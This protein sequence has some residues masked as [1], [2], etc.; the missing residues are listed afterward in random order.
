MAEEPWTMLEY[1]P[2]C[3]SSTYSVILLLACIVPITHA[4]F[5]VRQSFHVLLLCSED[6]A[7]HVEVAQVIL[8][9]NKRYLYVNY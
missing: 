7:L 9:F 6:A 2:R 8:H 4:G 3:M 1:Y 5:G